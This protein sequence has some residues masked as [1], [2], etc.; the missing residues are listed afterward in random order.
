[1][2]GLTNARFC[3]Y[4]ELISRKL[5]EINKM[6]HLEGGDGIV[7]E[8]CADAV[9]WSLSSGGKRIRPVLAL[10]FCRVCGR[11]PENALDAAAAVEMIHTYSLIHDDLPCMDDD[12][13]RRGRLSCHKKFGEAFGLL[14]GD[15]L[16]THAFGIVANS[17]CLSDG[18]K[19][20]IIGRLAE[21]AG[22]GGMIGGQVLDLSFENGGCDD[23]TSLIKMYSKK[24]SALLKCACE[25]GCICANAHKEKRLA[26]CEYA[27]NLGIAF[28]ITDDI[29]DVTQTTEALGKPAGSDEKQHKTTFVSLNGLDNAHADAAEYTE[30]ALKALELFDDNDFLV[31]LTRH[32][33]NRKN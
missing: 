13:Y 22:I 20:G 7:S 31:D 8:R 25:V 23:V 33:L 16:L 15:T 27:E 11:V 17:S 3:E 12:D 30:K 29:L 32:L 1:M 6:L 4:T 28:Q 24:T 5:S 2:N 14:A 10:E 26:A 21:Y 19:S 9:W 18:Q